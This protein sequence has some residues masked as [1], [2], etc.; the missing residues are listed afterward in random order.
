MSTRSAGI[1]AQLAGIAAFEA[2][3]ST[4]RYGRAMHRDDVLTLTDLN[5]AQSWRELVRW[6]TE[7]SIA[8]EDD[9]LLG[10]SVSRSP[11]FN[12]CMRTGAAGH[13]TAADVLARAEAYFSARSRGFVFDA[14]ER[15]DGDVMQLAQARGLGV[16]REPLPVMVLD[17]PVPELPLD[18]A[19]RLQIIDDPAGFADFARTAAGAFAALG[20]SEEVIAALLGQPERIRAPHVIAIVGYQ[21]ATPL[22]TG[23][24][25]LSHGV[26]G[27]YWIGTLPAAGRR[28]LGG[29]ITRRLGNLAFERGAPLVCL[30]SSDQGMPLYQRIGYR[31]VTH[32][33]RYLVP[34]QA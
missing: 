3:F 6:R 14:R 32:V 7:G 12:R 30:Q 16:V 21:G 17:H 9:L 27:I 31:T 18:P 28:G 22:A 8:E 10:A 25:L 15:L 2:N 26:G 24:L 20:A 11:G 1:V 13:P 34:R 19:L 29:A 4:P 33:H 5:Y 23:L